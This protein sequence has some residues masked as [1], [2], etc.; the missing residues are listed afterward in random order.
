MEVLEKKILS[1]EEWKQKDNNGNLTYTI[2]YDGGEGTYR[3][4][5]ANKYFVVGEVA[6]FTAEDMVS[7][8]NKPYK[9]LKRFEEQA[10]G[11]VQSG[12]SRDITK[13]EVGKRCLSYVV[14]AMIAGKVEW[15]L[16]E[17]MLKMIIEDVWEQVEAET[18]YEG[19]DMCIFIM[20]KTMA[21]YTSGNMIKKEDGE[22]DMKVSDAYRYMLGSVKNCLK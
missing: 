10:G 21:A 6:K 14:D 12:S 19:K 5:Y 1:I 4:K 22:T 17:T 7:K 11:V 2:K 16:F 9:K 20:S 8:S 13:Y 15:K 18:T 3:S